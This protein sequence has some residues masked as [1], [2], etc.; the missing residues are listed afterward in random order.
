MAQII[1]ED[2][3]DDDAQRQLRAEYKILCRCDGFK[4]WFDELARKLGA[5]VPGSLLHFIMSPSAEKR[6]MVVTC[7]LLF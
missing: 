2:L 5:V 3:S 1:D 6:I 7:S 4:Q